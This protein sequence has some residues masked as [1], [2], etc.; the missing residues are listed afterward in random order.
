[1]AVTEFYLEAQFT[2]SPFCACAVKIRPKTIRNVDKS[3]P[4]PPV[5]MKFM[6]SWKV[7]SDFGP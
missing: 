7:V 5:Y 4:F 1:M 6:P 3:S 2:Y